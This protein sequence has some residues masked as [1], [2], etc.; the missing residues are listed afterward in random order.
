[1]DG[2]KF[3]QM[4]KSIKIS[5]AI[6]IICIGYGLAALFSGD[7]K[8]GVF[9]ISVSMITVIINIHG[10]WKMEQWKKPKGGTK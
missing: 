8:F 2:L 5:I 6:A 9:L 1:M 3:E 7:V 4:M 10:H